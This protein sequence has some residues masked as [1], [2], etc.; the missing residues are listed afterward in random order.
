MR[1]PKLQIAVILLGLV[2][3]AFAE[4]NSPDSSLPIEVV[5][6]AFPMAI[7]VV[8]IVLGFF[9]IV[10]SHKYVSYFYWFIYV[11]S[12]FGVGMGLGLGLQVFL[13]GSGDRTPFFT[14]AGAVGYLCGLKIVSKLYSWR[15]EKAF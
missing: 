12:I 10:S 9:A 2:I 1:S 11:F 3:G 15:H 5:L 6:L 7:A 8:V 14:L 4:N 13:S